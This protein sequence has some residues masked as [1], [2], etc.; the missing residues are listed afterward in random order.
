MVVWVII[1]SQRGGPLEISGAGGKGGR[2]E[3]QGMKVFACFRGDLLCVGNEAVSLGTWEGG[4]S[5]P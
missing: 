3:K 1:V 2:E 5:A 4:G